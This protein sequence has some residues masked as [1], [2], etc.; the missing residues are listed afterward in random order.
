MGNSATFVKQFCKEEEFELINIMEEVETGKGFDALDRR[1]KLAEAL[2]IAKSEG[3]ILMVSKLDRLSRSVAFISQLMESKVNF[4]VTQLGKDADP[5]MLHLY[6]A[7][8]EKEREL[9]SQRTKSA[10][11]VLKGK[12]VAL[13]NKTNLDEARRL[14]NVTNRQQA[15]DF[16]NDMKEVILSYRDKGLSLEKIAIKLNT[17]GAKTRR[18]GKWYACTVR[19]VLNR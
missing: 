7:L 14:S 15:T 3:Y 1:P 11:Q 13:G 12:G 18:G 5:F 2:K 4:I 6:A 9:I 17:I 16:A 19:N 8:S 10:L